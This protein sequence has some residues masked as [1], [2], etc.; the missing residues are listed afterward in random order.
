MFCHMTVVKLCK[1]KIFVSRCLWGERGGLRPPESE[2]IFQLKKA[3]K[4]FF[5]D[6]IVACKKVLIRESNKA[7]GC[8]ER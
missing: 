5:D 3:S 2:H 6:I 4:A 7:T 1:V 8:E